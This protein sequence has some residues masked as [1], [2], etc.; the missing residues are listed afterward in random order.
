MP[1]INDMPPT[2]SSVQIAL[3]SVRKCALVKK[4]HCIFKILSLFLI[5]ALEINLRKNLR[6]PVHAEFAEE[7]L[8]SCAFHIT[9]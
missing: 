5:F 1:C 2:T 8:S 3:L 4:G 7:F 9:E 6:Q